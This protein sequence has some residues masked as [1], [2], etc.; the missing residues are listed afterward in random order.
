MSK[1]N[2][3]FFKEKHQD[4]LVDNL[5]RYFRSR[6]NYQILTIDNELV[7]KY[8]H[9]LF[10]YHAEF[11]LTP[12]SIVPNL[13][14]L[15]SRFLN[16][17]M[18]FNI[19]LLMPSYIANI[20]FLEVKDFIKHFKLY[21]Y[22]NLFE[23]VL[24]FKIELLNKTYEMLKTSFVENNPLILEDYYLVPK[25]KLQSILKYED[26]VEAL[27]KHYEGQ[28]IEIPSYVFLKK[29][30]EVKNTIWLYDQSATIFPPY[31]D[32]II[33]K[34]LDSTKVILYDEVKEILN[35]QLESVPGFLLGSKVLL[36]KQAKKAH[37]KIKKAKLSDVDI[38][39]EE[40]NLHNLIDL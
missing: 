33:Y 15:N 38:K 37:K 22:N 1:Y 28:D 31:T 25:T 11:R 6:A 26:E 19:S 27:K 32:L 40:I 7:F 35:K 12:K 8:T 14:K 23:D 9:P 36:E 21:T 4:I 10:K 20:L 2:L 30:D 24:S 34:Y 39:I 5:V 3:H 29:G 17:N 16:I 18:H 13:Y